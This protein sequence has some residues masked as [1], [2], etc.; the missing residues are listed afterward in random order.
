MKR[1]SWV[2]WRIY[3]LAIPIDV[4]VLVLAADHTLTGLKDI[5]IWALV[6]LIA[7]ATIAP[8]ISIAISTSKHF[9]NWRADLITLIILGAIRGFAITICINTFD[10]ELTVSNAYK[11]FNSAIALPQ[12]FIVL[13]IFIESRRSYQREF[14]SLFA[15]AMRKE[16]ETHERQ[17]LL[18]KGESSAEELIARL[19]F[20]TSN[21]ASDI[22][23]LLN[24]PGVL[25]DYSL[26]ATRIQNLIS[27][28]LRPASAEL[29][30]SNAVTTPKVSFAALVHISLLEQRLRVVPVVLFS[31]PYLFVGL[32][33]TY[34][35]RVAVIQSLFV[36]LFDLMV[37]VLGETLFRIEVFSRR[38]ANLLILVGGFFLPFFI[39]FS[40]FPAG[41]FGSDVPLTKFI[42][43]LFLSTTYI[44]LL[45][46]FN[47]YKVV[48][49]Q[50][51]EVI[52]SLERHLSGDKFAPTLVAGGTAIRNAD[53]AQYLHGEIQA[54]L[55]ASSLLLQQAAN[56]GDSELANEA[57][58]RAASLLNQDHTNIA[59]TRMATPE[60][61]LE[62][63]I[64]GW[65]GIADISILLPS[66]AQLDEAVL[67]NSVA[68][69][70]EAIANSIRHAHATEIKVSS[71]L[72]DDL[73]IINIISNGDS[74]TKGKAGLGTKLFNDLASEWSYSN[75]SGHNRLTFILVNRL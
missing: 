52:A 46:A 24:R 59:Y 4:V 75:E 54:G 16:Q 61:K 33:G 12:W 35:L 67:R 1:N 60:I 37:Y 15:K 28:D 7:H 53:I 9:N 10:L 47:S 62:K 43:Q 5:F 26:E 58:E 2:S 13:A 6:A 40:I 56:S 41:F 68:L 64:S 71:V 72:K 45:L 57:L 50:R 11:V 69:I 38:T 32:N 18:P 48:S 20:I 22:Q 44:T 49:E 3:L 31:V 63:I 42:Y 21:L 65:K 27:D 73:L 14:Q 51:R 19:Q 23:N 29:W 66:A 17:S 74:M 70:E 30:Q 34:S 39:Q 36:S 8:F 25:S 55:T